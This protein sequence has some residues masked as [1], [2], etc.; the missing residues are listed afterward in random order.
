[1]SVSVYVYVLPNSIRKQVLT[2]CYNALRE[3]G[4]T[5]EESKHEVS[6]YI[7]RSRLMDLEGL[8]DIGKYRL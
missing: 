3:R 8:I 5:H 4:K 1:M 2:D 7:T 6:H